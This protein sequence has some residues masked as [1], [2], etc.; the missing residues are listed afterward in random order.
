MALN[1]YEWKW[2]G[3]TFGKDLPVKVE[4]VE[5]LDDLTARVGDIALPR[6]HGAIRGLLLASPGGSG[7]DAVTRRRDRLRPVDLPHAPRGAAGRARKLP[8]LWHGA[9]AGGALGS[10]R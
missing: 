7:A 8:R 3:L 9:R 6:N 4:F 5:G 2:R 1:D 10:V